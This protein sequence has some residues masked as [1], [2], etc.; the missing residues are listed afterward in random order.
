MASLMQ[1]RDAIA[2]NGRM[3]ASQLSQLLAAPL[4]L[5]EAMLER[6]I[7]MG[8]LKRIEQDNSGCLSGGCKS[9]PEGQTC[10]TVVY[11]LKTH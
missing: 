4:P 10:N 5:I 7:A 3:E 2:L 8:K 1:L 9:C 11:Q 6:L